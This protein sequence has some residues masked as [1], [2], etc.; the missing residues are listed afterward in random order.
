MNETN[1]TGVN[2]KPGGERL[3]IEDLIRSNVKLL[4]ENR[5]LRDENNRLVQLLEQK[6]KKVREQA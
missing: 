3:N 6:R 2:K 4:E 1:S 5:R